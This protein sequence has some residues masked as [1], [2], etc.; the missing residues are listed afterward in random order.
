MTI[1]TPQQGDQRFSVWMQKVE[2]AGAPEAFGQDM[3][4]YQGQELDTGFA[5]RQCMP[6]IDCNWLP[7]TRRARGIRPWP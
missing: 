5:F 6:A 2:M 1:L 3:A 4:K 7:R